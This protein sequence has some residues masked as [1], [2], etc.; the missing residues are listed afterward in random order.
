MKLDTEFDKYDDGFGFIERVKDSNIIDFFLLM[1]PRVMSLVLF[2]V[3]VGMSLAPGSQ[4]PFLSVITVLAIAVGAG[5]AAAINMWYDRDIDFIMDR[6]KN[7]PIPSGKIAPDDALAF[8]VILAIL[9]ILTLF[10]VSNLLSAL[11]LATTIFFYVFIYTIWL[12]RKTV[13][14]IVI[15]GAAGA[16]PPLIG[17]TSVTG[18]IDF[19]P[20]I[21]FV[22]IFLWTPPHFWALAL[23]R[24]GEYSRVGVP[25]MPNVKGPERTIKEMKVYSILLVILSLA[26]PMSYGVMDDSEPVYYILGWTVVMLS[27]WYASTIWRIDISEEP[28]ETGR[29]ASA[30]SSFFASMLYLAMMF[31]VLVT[32]SFGTLGAAIGAIATISSIGKIELGTDS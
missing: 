17:W 18:S 20:L 2:T 25:M 24:S 22:I 1:K 6:T 11:L 19:L 4:H 14:N 9:S 7:R 15:G 3:F 30:A 13:Q 23:Y 16:L 8:G 28:D 10:L 5:S 31:A 27:I 32:A 26:A 12:K 29:I 21:M